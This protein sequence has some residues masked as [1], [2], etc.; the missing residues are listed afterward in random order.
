MQV[1]ENLKNRQIGIKHF[2][3]IAQSKERRDAFS[4]EFGIASDKLLIICDQ[5]KNK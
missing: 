5:A 3:E 2:I 4:K 1:R